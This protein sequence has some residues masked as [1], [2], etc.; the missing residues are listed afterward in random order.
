M[1]STYTLDIITDTLCKDDNQADSI[2]SILK[3]ALDMY[4]WEYQVSTD[5]QVYRS[6]KN[7][8]SLAVTKVVELLKAKGQ[9]TL[10]DE[11]EYALYNDDATSTLTRRKVLSQINKYMKKQ[12]I[13][14]GISFSKYKNE[15]S[16]QMET[17]FHEWCAEYPLEKA[18]E[19]FDRDFEPSIY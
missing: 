10:A 13:E 16:V 12:L 8:A 6:A 3:T 17:A 18:P 15:F 19:H 4:Q 2:R 11:V 1:K 9:N 5:N 14:G 7:G